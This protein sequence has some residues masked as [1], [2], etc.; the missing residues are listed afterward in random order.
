MKGYGESLI[1]SRERLGSPPPGQTGKRRQQSDRPQPSAATFR[2]MGNSTSCAPVLDLL[3]R[4]RIC[5]SKLRYAVTDSQTLHAVDHSRHST[6][7]LSSNERIVIV[8]A[9][10]VSD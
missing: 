3:P 9:L 1:R 8:R 5:H 6:L 10:R 2:Q 4:V 7:F